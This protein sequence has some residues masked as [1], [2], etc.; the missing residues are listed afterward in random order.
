M[1]MQKVFLSG[2][3]RV[4][5]WFVTLRLYEP[6]SGSPGNTSQ[7]ITISEDDPKCRLCTGLF[8]VHF[9]PVLLHFES[10]AIEG[11]GFQEIHRLVHSF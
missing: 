5:S 4:A 8:R 10:G 3:K 11:L 7:K 2:R 9:G 1:K 6:S